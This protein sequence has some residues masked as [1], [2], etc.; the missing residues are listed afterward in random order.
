MTHPREIPPAFA[1]YLEL[2]LQREQDPRTAG[3]SERTERRQSAGPLSGG[4]D[5]SECSHLG[6]L[7]LDSALPKPTPRS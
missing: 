2:L 1:G 5:A 4:R 6:F 7:A 3:T